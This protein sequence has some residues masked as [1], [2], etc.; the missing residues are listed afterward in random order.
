MLIV[1]GFMLAILPKQTKVPQENKALEPKQEQKERN[2]DREEADSQ[3]QIR[4]GGV[5]MIGP[6]PIA[7]GSDSRTAILMML[8]AL[9]IILVWAVS[10]KGI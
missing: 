3:S 1:L 8:I 2:Q 7:F 4:G 10:N 9:T 5:I 6:I